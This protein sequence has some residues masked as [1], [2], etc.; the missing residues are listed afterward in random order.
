MKD[1]ANYG[2][3]ELTKLDELDNHPI[4]GVKFEI[5]L[6]DNVVETLTT[7]AQGYA[8]SKDLVCGT[9][10]VREK[11]NPT[12]YVEEISVTDSKVTPLKVNSLTFKNRP[13]QGKIRIFKSDE[14]TK[15]A[16]ADAEF[17][18]TRIS[19]L[20]SHNGEGDGDVVAVMV[21]GTD[22][23]AETE[24]LTYGKYRDRKSVV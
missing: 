19:G 7:N 13:I 17:T 6:G 3:I 10:T 20:P 16:L 9:Y 21:T 5:V 4:A 18:V 2:W 11:D 8:K 1:K 24:L 14:L 12:G 23:I 22:G 15:E